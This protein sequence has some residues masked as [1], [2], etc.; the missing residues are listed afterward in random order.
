MEKNMWKSLHFKTT[1]FYI[2]KIPAPLP[3]KK[4]L[5]FPK[6]K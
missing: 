4:T 1:Y 2:E 6:P 3:A 5:V